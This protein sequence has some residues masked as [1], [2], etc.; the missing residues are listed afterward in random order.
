M[1]NL[2][3]NDG[4][5]D[6]QDASAKLVAQAKPSAI[7]ANVLSTTQTPTTQQTFTLNYV[8]VDNDN[9]VVHTTTVR[10]KVGE[11]VTVPNEVPTGYVALDQVPAEYT[12]TSDNQSVTVRLKHDTKQSTD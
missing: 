5:S 7:F 11:K 10:G 8:D 6:G 2:K 9:Q 12:F 3:I 4:K 1:Q